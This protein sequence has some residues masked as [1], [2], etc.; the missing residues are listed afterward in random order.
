MRTF[1]CV[2]MEVIKCYLAG[3]S[4]G[5]SPSYLTGKRKYHDVNDINGKEDNTVDSGQ[6]VSGFLVFGLDE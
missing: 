6:M 1:L 4:S 3:L 5:V 2:N